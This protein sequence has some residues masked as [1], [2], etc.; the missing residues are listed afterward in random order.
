[1]NGTISDKHSRLRY[2]IVVLNPVVRIHKKT[3]TA[4]FSQ[5]R[6]HPALDYIFD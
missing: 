3:T 2:G 1:M 5:F 4:E 6:A